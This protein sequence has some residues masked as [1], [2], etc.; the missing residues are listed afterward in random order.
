MTT[1]RQTVSLGVKRIFKNSFHSYC[2]L[3]FRR[4]MAAE[5]GQRTHLYIKYRRRKCDAAA[6]V[7]QGH[8]IDLFLDRRLPIL[9][10]VQTSNVKGFVTYNL[11]QKRWSE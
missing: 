2:G 8:Q 7:H 1:R 4:W 3:A 11:N 5:E 9:C 6:I 10:R